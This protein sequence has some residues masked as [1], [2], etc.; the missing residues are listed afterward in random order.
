METTEQTQK[1]N[2]A[3]F[4]ISVSRYFLVFLGLIF[5]ALPFVIY[6]TEVHSISQLPTWA[7]FVYP[8]FIL[9]GLWFIWTGIFGSDKAAQE[10][11]NSATT[12]EIFIIP[13]LMLSLFYFIAKY[14]KK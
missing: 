12:N 3:R 4:W 8:S 11:I 10:M 14:L 6:L 2:S 13:A 9:L 1:R 7:Y 5:L